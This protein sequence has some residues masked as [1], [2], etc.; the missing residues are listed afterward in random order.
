MLRVVL[1]VGV[2]CLLA[3]ATQAQCVP[4]SLV[5]G[6]PGGIYPPVL[7]AATGCQYYE[8]VIS[9]KFPQDTTVMFAGQTITVNFNY[10]TIDS[11]TGLPPGMTWACNLAPNCR[12]LV[13]PDSSNL[14]TIGC[15]TLS[16]TPN[17][18]AAYTLTVHVTATVNLFGNP[19]D[20]PTAFSRSLQVVPCEF[21]GD[22]YNLS[23]SDNCAPSTLSITNNV[24]RNGK[25][26][27]T[28]DWEIN[29]PS[30]L[31]YQ[32]GDEN[33]FPQ[34][35]PEGGDYVVDFRADID[36]IGY[37]LQQLEIVKLGCTDPFGGQPDLYW[38]LRRPNNQ[39]IFNTQGSPVS[40]ATLPL[41]MGITNLLL[42][43]GQWRIQVWDDETIGAPTG[44]ATGGNNTG[45]N[46]FFTIPPAQTGTFTLTSG[47]LDIRFTIVNPVQ[48]ITCRDTIHVDSL[49]AVPTLYRDGVAL[50]TNRTYYCARGGITLATDSRDS[51]EWFQDGD[52]ILGAT[53]TFLL[54]NEAG[55]YTVD[56]IDRETF[57]RVSA[58]AIQVDSVFVVPPSASYDAATETYDINQPAAAVRYEWYLEDGSYQAAGD[59]FAPA[60]NGNYFA[61]AVDTATGCTSAPTEVYSFVSGVASRLVSQ[62]QAYP[63]PSTG[64][65]TVQGTLLRA[66]NLRL[67]VSDLAGRVIWQAAYGRQRDRFEAQ[68]D[69][70]QL[71]AGV[72]LLTLSAD[73]ERE[74][75]RLMLR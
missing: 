64:Q 23:L 16:G 22:C 39:I 42:D 54:V 58:M 7:P 51:L 3:T 1:L 4:D 35:L 17:I 48:T 14:D 33:P 56:A 12:Y 28:Y 20:Q 31:V 24:P 34:T 70:E 36:T 10:F 46:L 69:L 59:S 5:N 57:C 25:A 6:T 29:G 8:Q 27:F 18:P 32:T 49:P 13:H 9:F 40:N 67:Q 60:N 50:D 73:Q 55:I 38:N 68:L 45:A 74:V 30:G 66:A 43:T 71:S 44:C 37:V 2:T 63:N 65:V 47:D 19:S 75:I 41:D 15:V 53:D 62:W 52:L 11:I 26:G 72:Y 61:V 21:E